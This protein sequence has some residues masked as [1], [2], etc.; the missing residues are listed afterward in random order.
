MSLTENRLRTQTDADATTPGPPVRR[1]P[2]PTSGWVL[3]LGLAWI[4]FVALTLVL[5]P[6]PSG[7]IAWWEELIAL[8]QLGVLGSVAAGLARRAN[9]APAASLA[10]SG[11]FTVSV[12]ACPATGHHAFGLWWFGEFAAVVSLTALSGAAVWRSRRPT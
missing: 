8:V 5:E 2:S 10:A 9:W 4:A 12:F 1:P 7:A 3:A 11:M 6:A